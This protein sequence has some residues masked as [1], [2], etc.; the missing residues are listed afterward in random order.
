MS[1]DVYLSYN[2]AD[3]AAVLAIAERLKGVGLRVWIDVWEI[4]PGQRWNDQIEGKFDEVATAAIFVGRSGLGPWQRLETEVLLE[5][6]VRRGRP[7]IPVLLE[8]C[9]EDPKLPPYLGQRM[10]VDFRRPETD[11]F[12]HLVWGITG[13]RP[14]DQPTPRAAAAH[15]VDVDVARLP[16]T[17]GALFGREAE[18]AMLDA[19]W[20]GESRP[21]VVSLVAWG[22]AGK[23]ALVGR[24]LA[25]LAGD[26][27]RGAERVFGWSFYS[28]G[29]PGDQGGS[30]DG[31]I[32]TLLRRY[33]DPDPSAGS[34]EEKGLRLATL[35]RAKRTLLILDGVER[36]Q[37][38]PGPDTGRLQ[39]RGLTMLLRSLAA[40]NPGLCV[41]TTR[42]PLTDLAGW[43]GG[44]ARR[45][46]LESLRPEAGSALLRS[47]G[48]NGSEAELGVTSQE[49]GGHALTLSLLGRY[50]ARRFGGDIA[51]RRE[52]GPLEAETTT[53]S[54]AAR[55]LEAYAEWWGDSPELAVLHILGLF[56]R[57]ASAGALA[58]VRAESPSKLPALADRF[59]KSG[60]WEEAVANLRAARLV[61]PENINARG[62]LDAHPLV[63]EHF[64]A[65]FRE[66]NPA[67]WREGHGRLFEY[68]R[69]AA[70]DLPETLEEMAPLYAAVI[71]GCRA[72]RHEEALHDVFIR[73]IRRGDQAFST[74]RLGAFA[75]DLGVMARFFDPPWESVASGLSTS[76]RRWLQYEA[77]FALLAVGRLREAVVLTEGG[78]RDAIASADWRES[79]KSA[80][81]LSELL[82]SRGEVDHAVDRASDAVGYADRSSDPFRSV[83]ARTLLANATYQAGRT[84]EAEELFREAERLQAVFQPEFP[85]LYGIGGYR[86]RDLLLARG[87]AEE[88]LR[89]GGRTRAWAETAGALL[90]NA[91]EHLARGRALASVGEPDDARACLDAAVEGLRRS[92]W[93]D[94]LLHGLL[95]R[96]HLHL[97]VAESPGTPLD[98]RS[99]AMAGARADLDETLDLATHY[100]MPLFEADAA[101]A[102]AR[103]HLVNEDPEAARRAHA[104]AQHLVNATGYRRRGADI[105]AFSERLTGIQVASRAAARAVA[106][107]E[108]VRAGL[109]N[110]S[111]ASPKRLM[112]AA[113]RRL[114]VMDARPAHSGDGPP[115]LWRCTLPPM[116]LSFLDA[117]ALVL[118]RQRD[119]DR[120]LSKVIIE[121]GRDLSPLL[122]LDLAELRRPPALLLTDTIWFR[123]D[124]VLEMAGQA[125][126]E[127]SSWLSRYITSRLRTLDALPFQTKGP[128]QF[129]FGRQAE[130]T[131]LLGGKLPGGIIMGA[132]RSGKTSLLNRAADELR[133]RN[134]TVVGTLT[135][136]TGDP[137][138]LFEKTLE[139]LGELPQ[140][141]APVA[142][143][144]E[145]ASAIRRFRKRRGPPSFFLD[146][147]DAWLEADAR[148]GYPIGKQ[149]RALQSDGMCEFY[150]AGHAHLRRATALEA[151]PL[152]NFAEEVTLTGLAESDAQRLI[153]EPMHDLGF[154]VTDDC[155]SRISAGTSGVPVL[156]QE[157]CLRLLEGHRG[158]MCADLS[159]DEVSRVEQNSAYLSV[160]FDHFKYAQSDESAAIMFLTAILGRANRQS[161]VQEFRNLGAAL[162]REALD[163]HLDFLV[164][165]GVLREGPPGEF[166]VLPGYL[167]TAIAAR[168]PREF[169]KGAL[170]TGPKSS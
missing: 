144:S 51:R 54:V 71:H 101:L 63:R 100:T 113:L 110:L 134:R 103:W 149:M 141:G 102:S 73:R 108:M 17:E 135:L 124:E 60:A 47:L 7:I 154:E 43:E 32:A 20:S 65:R 151:G 131:R 163:D 30:A 115:A 48:V 146:E 168:A 36:L 166:S 85:L 106:D 156:I 140:S 58:A 116:R 167:R 78:L 104:H 158:E 40:S 29:S 37:L 145:W 138:F 59:R 80:G 118:F 87:D 49:Y 75:A 15:A 169:V 34:P 91:L 27:W 142:G 1:F 139:E 33:G 79:A 92:S 52:V 162:S 44:F 18:L 157:F 67:A 21:H 56:D 19:A 70:S 74:D 89:R 109:R 120:Q 9:P 24:W 112:E 114:G 159:P 53:G 150:L 128:A 107:L 22:G 93:V 62:T 12:R 160:V 61:A 42:L 5:Q 125:D 8:N 165:F 64:G 90:D 81:N 38:P 50:L 14:E 76:S 147:V 133:R 35:V 41:L 170:T 77:A 83:V 119:E 126:T 13:R 86:H 95:A 11:P 98:A 26:G 57:P 10:W 2:S 132:H 161:L 3:R 39:D 72:Q 23:S 155:A 153:Q 97:A 69:R 111:S 130:L 25:R 127:R 6:L 45:I 94:H 105:A 82:I 121:L 123:R 148:H 129:F 164:R 88:V 143:L 4:V 31:M 136:G 84:N 99:D 46:D 117:E 68:Y 96:A 16:V 152:R 137:A 55:V 122:V 66:R 28:Q